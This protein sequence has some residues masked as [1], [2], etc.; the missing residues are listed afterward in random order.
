MGNQ[1]SQLSASF[2]LG[3][4]QVL[5]AYFLFVSECIDD[6]AAFA[7]LLGPLLAASMYYT[8]WESLV[9]NPTQTRTSEWNVE[10]PRVLDLTPS[11]R[12]AFNGSIRI[13]DNLDQRHPAILALTALCMSRQHA[14]HLTCL[15][16]LILIFHAIWSRRQDLKMLKSDSTNVGKEAIGGSK[17][18]KLSEWRRSWAI[19]SFSFIVTAFVVVLKVFADCLGLAKGY[20]AFFERRRWIGYPDRVLLLDLTY[21]DI[22]IATLFFQFS[23]YVS[24]R[25]ARRGFTLGELGIICHAAT[26]L[27]M[28]TV[29]LTRTRV[30][31]A[32]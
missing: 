3:P 29:N 12:D 21:P 22:V 2:S 25:L 31:G 20:G 9:K 8:S 23:L 10:P 13:P 28:E 7:L 27:F 32:E 1:R 30:S 15:L 14:V 11:P 18:I 26:G 19:I 16:S 6:G 5:Y 17:W 4:V 24:V